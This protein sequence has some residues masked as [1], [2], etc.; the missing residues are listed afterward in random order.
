MLLEIGEGRRILL[1]QGGGKVPGG[2]HLS[3]STPPAGPRPPS[4]DGPAGRPHPGRRTG[5]SPSRTGR[6]RGGDP[7]ASG[8]FPPPVPAGVS[9]RSWERS[10]RRWPSCPHRGESGPAA[11]PP[12]DRT[13][14]GRSGRRGGCSPHSSG[15]GG[16][17]ETPPPLGSRPAPWPGRGSGGVRTPNTVS[18]STVG[19]SLQVKGPVGRVPA[20]HE[21]GLN[22]GKRGRLSRA[23]HSVS[24]GST[25]TPFRPPKTNSPV[26]SSTT[27]VTMRVPV[28]ITMQ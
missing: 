13:C 15:G 8:G 22:G 6:C 4:P 18:G 17:G 26:A 11:P 9:G 3:N 1:G 28:L 21:L 16:L 25:G 7:P 24:T 19:M 10:D 14:S 5:A 27:A 2:H 12:R 20:G 23:G